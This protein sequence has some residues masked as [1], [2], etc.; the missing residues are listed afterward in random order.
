[1]LIERVNMRVLI[2]LVAM[3]CTGL[4]VS[5]A[6]G[7]SYTDGEAGGPPAS[8][9]AQTFMPPQAGL[10]DALQPAA[11]DAAGV[12][13]RSPNRYAN[14]ASQSPSLLSLAK[15]LQIWDEPTRRNAQLRLELSSDV[16]YENAVLAHEVE[17]LWEAGKYD[18]A[19][20]QLQSLE[21]SGAPVAMGVNWLSPPVLGGMNDWADVRIGT[22]TG[23]NIAKIDFDHASG[24]LFAVVNW[25][26]DNGWALYMSIDKGATWNETY[27][28]YAGTGQQALDVDM[29]VVGDYVY[30]GYVASNIA[31]EARLRRN[32]VSTGGSDNA[33]SHEIVLDASPN[34]VTELAV[35]SNADGHSRTASS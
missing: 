33:Y 12:P 14:A 6:S 7:Q 19:I 30:T 8:S 22:R 2:T 13:S 17:A 4:M 27:F 32:L 31:N 21:V 35:E 15:R 3:M 26:T 24:K 5:A 1:M 10:D 18:A 20:A 29:T 23:G 11:N 25:A 34:T 28:W 16:S 9:R